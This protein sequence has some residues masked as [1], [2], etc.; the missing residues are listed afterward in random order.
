MTHRRARFRTRQRTSL[1][2]SLLLAL[3][4]L[5]AGRASAQTTRDTRRTTPQ[6]SS[7]QTTAARPR[8]VLVIVV[9]QFRADYL[10]RFGDLFATTGGLRR[11]MTNGAQWTNANYDHMPTYTAPGHAT[12]MTGAWP[13]ETGIV[14]NDWYDREVGC[15]VSNSSDPEDKQVKVNTGNLCRIEK[16]RWQLFGGGTNERASSPRRLIASTVGDEMRLVTNNRSK[17]IGVSVKDRGAM[18]PA[19]RHANA[20]YWFSALTGNMVTSSYYFNELPAWVARY[21]EARPADKYCGMQWTRLLKDTGEY[22]RRAG[23]DAPAWENIGAAK[24]TNTFPHKIADSPT[25]ATR[26]CW[27]MLDYT[28]FSNDLL[29]GF[30]QAAIENENL[31]SDADTDVLTVSFSANDY[32][33]HRFGPYSQEAMDIALRT[34]A[35]I[36]ALLD[37]VNTK[38]G[39]QNTL[40]AFTADHGVAPIPEHASAIGLTG[41]RIG[42]TDIMNAARNAVRARFGRKDE[43]K[44][45]TADYISETL[46]NANIFFNTVALKRDGIN[47]EEI[48]RV[49][50]EAVLTVPGINRAFTRTQ[51]ETGSVSAADPIARR[52]LHGFHPR[53]SGDVI[54]VQEPF[55][56]FSEGANPIP[57][58]HGSP[59]AY[60]THVP[61]II[62]GQGAAAGRYAQAATPADIAPTLATIL[63]IQPPSNS[64]GRVLTEGLSSK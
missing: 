50:L 46:S 35:Q 4:P 14:A 15:D 29:V 60:D 62:M 55:K 52:V 17:V 51:L 32:V 54:L 19:G 38:V 56:Y 36:G 49:V 12:V 10:E 47:R 34:D 59:Y 41:G 48:E 39:L 23:E 5:A 31:G 16:S 8:L 18:L 42:N 20:A 6:P 21:N 22:E 7:A 30:A 45:S 3:V 43:A 58:T 63:R 13:A 44:D 64:V 11:L 24:D 61:L 9:D 37:Y 28:P 2:L 53:R 33:G 40:V 27:G 57:A 1:I 26:D 25:T